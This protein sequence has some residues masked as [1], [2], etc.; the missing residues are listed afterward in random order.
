[1][2]KHKIEEYADGK[3]NSMDLESI[4]SI[5]GNTANNPFEV[6]TRADLEEKMENM[7]LLDL[8]SFAVKAGV[9]PSGGKVAIKNR[10]E[11]AFSSFQKGVSQIQLTQHVVD[12]NSRAGKRALKILEGNA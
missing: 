3:N 1:M 9:F 10:L 12:P 7:S 5:L 2:K 11:K 8:Q 4:E 6:I